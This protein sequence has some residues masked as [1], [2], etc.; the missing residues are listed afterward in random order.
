MSD[1]K[2]STEE[3]EL[4]STWKKTKVLSNQGSNK[5]MEV[6]IDNIK[7][8]VL[9]AR[10]CAKYLGQTI[11]FEQ[12]ETT[13]IKNRIRAACASFTKC[14]HELTSRSYLLRHRLRLFNTVITPTLTHASGTWTL[15]KEQE[16][17]IRSTQRKIVRLVVQKQR[18]Y[19]KKEAKNQADETKN[20][21]ESTGGK[22]QKE[23]GGSQQDTGDE[24]D[25]GNSTKT[26]CDQHSDLS[27]LNDTDEDID[28][29]EVE[30]KW[31]EYIKRSTKDAEEEMRAATIPCWIETQRKMKWRVAMRIAAHSESRWTQKAAKWNP[32][33]SIEAKANRRAGRLHPKKTVKMTS[34]NSLSKRHR[35]KQEET[36]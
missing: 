18:K 4:R 20:D 32:G 14:K 23:K 17:L 21:E 22:I 11:M 6:T 5:R 10:E 12:Q 24:T 34:I 9:P 36:T 26:E 29:A 31:I 30:E 19:K 13:E 25:E 33:P 27:F 15:S 3:V 35:K 8:E 28:T 2:R 7:V 16:K 1:S